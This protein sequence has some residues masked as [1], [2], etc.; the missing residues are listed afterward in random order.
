MAAKLGPK[1]AIRAKLLSDWSPS[2]GAN[3]PECVLAC[4]EDHAI[5]V[6]VYSQSL[7]TR[8]YQEESPRWIFLAQVLKEDEETLFAFATPEERKIFI[9]LKELPAIGPKKAATLMGALGVEG[10]RSLLY[11]ESARAF[12]V[13]GIG[14]KTLSQISQ[15]LQ[16]NKKKFSPLLEVDGDSEEAVGASAHSGEIKQTLA[17]PRA[18]LSP[19]LLKGVERLGISS[20]EAFYIY[21][22][23]VEDGEVD[24]A[25]DHTQLL[26][27]MLQKWGQLNSTS[28]VR[29]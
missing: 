13:P 17:P 10:L 1:F 14:P 6:E 26:S 18:R 22:K 20:D 12:K 23:L 7:R 8:L 4:G 3:D 24:E 15:G 29:D 5:S 16:N 27:K 11:G 28:K 21:Q 9:A 25:I 2:L 19:A